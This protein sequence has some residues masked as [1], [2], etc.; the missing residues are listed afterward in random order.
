[1]GFSAESGNSMESLSLAI[2]KKLLSK[3][4]DMI[5]GNFIDEAMGTQTNRVLTADKNGNE[6]EWNTMSKA[7]LAWQLLSYLEPI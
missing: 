4:A 6:K 5:V 3:N 7:D 2:H 1:M